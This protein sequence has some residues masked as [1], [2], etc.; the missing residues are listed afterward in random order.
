MN[1][2]SKKKFRATKIPRDVAKEENFLIQPFS[3]R[4]LKEAVQDMKDNKAAGIDELRV[5]QIKHFGQR[6]LAWILELMNNCVTSM[7]IPKCWRKARV[8]ALLK[9]GKDPTEAKNYRPI[10]LLCHLFKVL[11][12]MIL[13]R[14]SD[15]VDKALINEEAGFRPGRS[16]CRQVLNLTRY[17]EDGYERG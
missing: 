9:P 6:T 17:I 12:R 4:E 8:V 7:Q 16:C 13:K 1:G 3:L 15:Y 5:E 2:K 11:E 14:I 10:S